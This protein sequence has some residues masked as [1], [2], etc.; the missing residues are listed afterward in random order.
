MAR[1]QG[2][3]LG[4][5]YKGCQRLRGLGRGRSTSRRSSFTTA[6]HAQVA[7]EGPADICMYIY[8]YIHTYILTTVHLLV[9]SR[10]TP[11]QIQKNDMYMYIYTY[12]YIYTCIWSNSQIHPVSSRGF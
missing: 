12:T 10:V 5:G 3:V 8:I 6:E 9:M 11:H 4:F 7:P 2:E 1:G